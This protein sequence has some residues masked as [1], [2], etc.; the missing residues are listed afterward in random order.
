[1]LTCY[2][3]ENDPLNIHQSILNIIP[4]ILQYL[5]EEIYKF[6]RYLKPEILDSLY[7]EGKTVSPLKEK[8][9][10]IVKQDECV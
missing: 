3:F 4:K 5:Y 8:A 1:M 2:S 10:L 6:N 7:Q 9:I